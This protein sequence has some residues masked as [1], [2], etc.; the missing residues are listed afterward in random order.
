VESSLI[1]DRICR[2]LMEEAPDVPVVTIHDMNLTTSK[3]RRR[4]EQVLCE[5]YARVGLHPTLN[6]EDYGRQPPPKRTPKPR[7][8]RRRRHDPDQAA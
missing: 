1:I 4:V 7:R 2:R 8:R 3:N 6:I 5:E